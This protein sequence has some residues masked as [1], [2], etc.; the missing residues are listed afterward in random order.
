MFESGR[1][2][3]I[4]TSLMMSLFN[5]VN[6]LAETGSRPCWMQSPIAIFVWP[7]ESVRFNASASLCQGRRGSQNGDYRVRETNLPRTP[8][9]QTASAPISTHRLPFLI[10]SLPSSRELRQGVI[11][12]LFGIN[13]R[14]SAILTSFVKF[15]I[16][17]QPAHGPKLQITSVSDTTGVSSL[18]TF[19]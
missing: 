1:T 17:T 7:F 2:P 19:L 10:A 18:S 9:I 12:V 13:Q 6:Y 4:V 15:T 16:T 5:F 11:N 8:A 3:V 14:P